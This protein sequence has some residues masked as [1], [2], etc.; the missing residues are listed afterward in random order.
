VQ[1]W[2]SLCTNVL[3]LACRVAGTGLRRAMCWRSCVMRCA[4]S[5]GCVF[6]VRNSPGILSYSP[7]TSSADACRSA[8]NKARIPRRTRGN[9]SVQC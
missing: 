3:G 9:A 5:I 2:R 6:G 7:Y 4:G 8:L 1:L